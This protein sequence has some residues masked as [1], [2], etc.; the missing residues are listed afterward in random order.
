MSD[1][2]AVL[3]LSV[4]ANEQ[5]IR[6][7]YLELVRKFPPDS[8]PDRFAEIRAAYDE[9]SD[10]REQLRRTLFRPTEDS[11]SAII[12]DLNSASQSRRIPTND[13]LALGRDAC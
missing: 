12:A 3:N 7:R 11:L 13:L 1:P 4:T 2:Y 9:L 10:P 6:A 8:A 5:E